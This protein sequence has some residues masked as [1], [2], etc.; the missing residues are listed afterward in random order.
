ML[1]THLEFTLI[2]SWQYGYLSLTARLVKWSE[3][4]N[5]KSWLSLNISLN[6]SGFKGIATTVGD[7]LELVAVAPK[8]SLAPV[9][10]P[11][12]G[13]SKAQ[14]KNQ[15]PSLVRNIFKLTWVLLFV[16]VQ[17]GGRTYSL[18]T[19]ALR[20]GEKGGAYIGRRRDIRIF[21]SGWLN[22]GIAVVH[23]TPHEF[24]ADG[25]GSQKIGRREI[26]ERNGRKRNKG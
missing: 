3:T 14:T 6:F 2:T 22:G 25:K 20:N 17:Y 15:E 21:N 7:V 24:N 16:Q 10:T 13:C 4:H 18:K 26:K 12:G 19:D 9:V 1:A 11:Y 23:D 5:P 8:G